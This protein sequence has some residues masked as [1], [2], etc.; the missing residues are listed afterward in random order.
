VQHA[1]T[2]GGQVNWQHSIVAP[3]G[4]HHICDGRPLYSSRFLQVQKFHVPGLASARDSS[5]A[6]HIT[7]QGAAGYATRF[8]Q[9]WGFYDERAAV[10]DGSGWL[11]ILPDGQPLTKDRHAWCGNFQE[12]RCTVRDRGGR[13]RHIRIDGILAYPA[14]YLYAG[15]FRDGAAVVRCPQRGLCTHINPNGDLIHDTWL[16]DL[17]VFHKGLARARDQRGWFH[18]TLQGTEAYIGRFAAIEPFY[19]GTALAETFD[20]RRVL[21]GLDGSE[22]LPIVVTEHATTQRAAVVKV[23]VVGNIGSGKTGVARHLADHFRWPF[24]GIDTLRQ[25]LGDGTAAGE[26]RAWERF[27]VDSQQAD[28]RVLEFSGSGPMVHLVRHALS[29]SGGRVIVLWIDAPIDVCLSRIAGRTW[30]TPYPD[31]GVPMDSVVRDLGQRL[32]REFGG[33]TR[34]LGAPVLPLDGRLPQTVLAAQ[35]VRAVTGQL[36][37][38]NQ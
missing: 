14:T 7:P 28:A 11:H 27:A 1:A 33:Q 20:G 26:F 3:D 36:G 29:R 6:F 4:T 22:A 38:L 8:K 2:G 21:V 37:A 5:G 12:G 35:A 16:I 18:V 30:E 9:T 10:E 25:Q 24:T 19:N 31:F 15:D 34:W 17:D 23:L 13:Y 32:L